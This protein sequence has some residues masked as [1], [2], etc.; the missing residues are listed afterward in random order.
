MLFNSSTQKVFANFPFAETCLFHCNSTVGGLKCSHQYTT[1]HTHVRT[2]KVCVTHAASRSQKPTGSSYDVVRLARVEHSEDQVLAPCPMVASECVNGDVKIKCA[3]YS[4]SDLHV[5]ASQKSSR[6]DL[7][8]KVDR[9]E[10]QQIRRI[11]PELI[12]C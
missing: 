5:V 10:Q 4:T 1:V 7:V 8:L 2:G 3:H 9:I 11:L 12:A 6:L